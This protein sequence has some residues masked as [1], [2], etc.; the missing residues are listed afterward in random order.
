MHFAVDRVWG[1][2][3]FLQGLGQCESGGTG[4]RCACA[5]P[6]CS[7]L[8]FRPSFAEFRCDR[9]VARVAGTSR[10]WDDRAMDEHTR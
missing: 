3:E 6:M 4:E 2:R 10:K 1:G 7:S 9:C 8:L 5:L